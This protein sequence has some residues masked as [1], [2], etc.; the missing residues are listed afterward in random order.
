[1]RILFP[2]AALAA[3][4]LPVSA[5]AQSQ[6]PPSVQAS[7]SATVSVAPDEA[8]ILIGVITQASNAAAAA[9]Q[10]AAQLQKALD[11][12]KAAAGP[13]AEVK[14]VSYSL[15]PNYDMKSGARTIRSFTANDVVQVTT[16]D[17]ASVGRIVDAAT[18]SGA[19]EIQS[20]QFTLKDPSQAHAQ[21]LRKAALQAH[22]EVE[23]MAS[24]LGLKLGKVLA[25]DEASTTPIRPFVAM[26]SAAMAGTPIQQPQTIDVTATVTLTIA[27]EQ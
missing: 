19:N 15:T 2:A 18:Q 21:A 16:S 12:W 13:K 3:L 5:G 20:L 17:L 22:S 26:Q 14:T 24:A 4:A 6:R 9:S 27:L 1:M 11:E 7:G 10:N 25:L 8:R 23:A